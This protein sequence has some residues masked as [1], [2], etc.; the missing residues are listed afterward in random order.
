MKRRLFAFLAVA[1]I[2]VMTAMASY[3]A[4]VTYPLYKEYFPK[5]I[6]F[7][8][9]VVQDN[10][11][12]T[13][14]NRYSQTVCASCGQIVWYNLVCVGK[15]DRRSE[16]ID[17]VFCFSGYDNAE[18]DVSVLS[19]INDTSI[20]CVVTQGKGIYSNCDYL[21][22]N[23]NTYIYFHH[24]MATNSYA[25]PCYGAVIDGES[26]VGIR[27]KG[28]IFDS[29]GDMAMYAFRLTCVSVIYDLAYYS[30]ADATYNDGYKNGYYQGIIRGQED[31]KI[32]SDFDGFFDGLF[33]GFAGFIS[34]ILDIGIGSFTVYNVLQ[35]LLTV[36]LV[37]A[38][39]KIM[40]G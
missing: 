9:G 22:M 37:L 38:L 31:A 4:P 13:N 39:I 34:P 26:D 1:V 10:W 7:D 6:V 36:Y 12:N 30:G 2:L 19:L 11:S 27:I 33:S 21:Y 28:N 15:G 17:D 23:G 25:P 32:L 14:Y 8:G 24:E 29:L 40:K 20:G 5:S 3:A 16:I 35:L 18:S